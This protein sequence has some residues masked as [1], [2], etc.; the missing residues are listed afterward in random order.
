MLRGRRE[1][2]ES[3]MVVHLVLHCLSQ[4]GVAMNLSSFSGSGLSNVLHVF[5][6][7]GGGGLGVGAQVVWS[8]MFY[9]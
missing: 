3:A 2:T 1:L 7:G 8:S 4:I 5:W 6:G 9:R